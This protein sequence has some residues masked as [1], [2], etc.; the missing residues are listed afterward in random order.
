MI[1]IYRLL[2]I[3]GAAFA[4]TTSLSCPQGCGHCCL[5]EKVE[6]TILECIPQ[7]F[8]LFRTS[9]AEVVLQRLAENGSKK[10]CIL[11]RPDL[12]HAGLWGC[13][14]YGTRVVVCRLFGF[15]GSLDPDGLARL[16]LCQVMK[17][18][19]GSKQMTIIAE[20]RLSAMPLF[21]E[22]GLRI[23][24]LHPGLGTTRMPINAA[25]WQALMKVGMFLDL[26]AVMIPR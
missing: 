26:Q 9:Q 25:L 8:H 13:S 12:T 11:Y 6:A 22:A 3:A 24:A 21:A 19:A 18:M 7:A 5:S 10:P 2:D 17:A 16:A 23:T 14:E 4:K 15:A 1:A 20:N